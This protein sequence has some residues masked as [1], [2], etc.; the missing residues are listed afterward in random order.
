MGPVPADVAPLAK[1]ELQEILNHVGENRKAFYFPSHF[2]KDYDY[3]QRRMT[4]FL[5]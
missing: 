4:R 5:T 2:Y 3:G 1:L